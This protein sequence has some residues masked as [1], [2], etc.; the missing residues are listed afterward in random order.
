MKFHFESFVQLPRFYIFWLETVALHLQ[1][2]S[3]VLLNRWPFSVQMSFLP[4]QLL[5]ATQ[6]LSAPTVETQ[7]GIKCH[8]GGLMKSH[9]FC[10]FSM[11]WFCQMSRNHIFVIVVYFTFHSRCRSA[12]IRQLHLNLRLHW[13][14]KLSVGSCGWTVGL[15]GQ[16]TQTLTPQRAYSCFAL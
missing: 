8:L 16:G 9:T 2:F 14:F 5:S 1:K 7:L 15:C 6:P 10:D 12:H 13:D 3:S 4:A 11:K